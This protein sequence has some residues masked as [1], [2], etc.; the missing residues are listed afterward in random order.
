MPAPRFIQKQADYLETRLLERKYSFTTTRQ[1]NIRKL[2]CEQRDEFAEEYW[3]RKKNCKSNS[4]FKLNK[5]IRKSRTK[6]G[7]NN[8]LMKNNPAR[9]VSNFK[10][11]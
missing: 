2:K 3:Q 1:K 4:F 11:K 10:E 8:V 9:S 6:S 5:F 7:Q